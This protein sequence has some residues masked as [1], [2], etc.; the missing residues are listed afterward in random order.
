MHWSGRLPNSGVKYQCPMSCVLAIT[1][2]AVGADVQRIRDGVQI[3]RRECCEAVEVP[4]DVCR[5]VE[6]VVALSQFSPQNMP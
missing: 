2:V 5:R 6:T 3:G 4:V 1:Y